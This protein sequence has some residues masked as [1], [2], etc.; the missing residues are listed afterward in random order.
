MR[1]LGPCFKTGKFN[2]F[3]LGPLAV[4]KHECLTTNSAVSRS[5]E[6][7]GV[8]PKSVLEDL[9]RCKE[10]RTVIYSSRPF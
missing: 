1:L 3:L 4:L 10:P 9:Y 7:T 5:T 2:L 8:N 6:A